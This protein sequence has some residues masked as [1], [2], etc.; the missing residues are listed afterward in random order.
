MIQAA[1]P[2]PQV[3]LVG[4]HPRLPEQPQEQTPVNDPCAEVAI[5]PQ[6]KPRGSVV[7]EED[8]NFPPAVQ[9]LD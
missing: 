2:A 1:A 7:K 5:K 8:L 9:A 6:L 3:A 4:A